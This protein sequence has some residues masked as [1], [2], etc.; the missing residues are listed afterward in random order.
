VTEF[1]LKFQV[2]PKHRAAVEEAVARGQSRKE[3][4]EARY[5]D[6]AD[7]ALAARRIVLRI[8]KEGRRWVQT[9]MRCSGM[10]TT[11]RSRRPRP[12]MCRCRAWSAMPAPLSAH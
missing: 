7:G 10:N 11:S 6:T 8:R 4:L 12:A 5:Y 9:A 2:D 1:E 3:R